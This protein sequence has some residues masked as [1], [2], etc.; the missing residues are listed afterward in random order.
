MK[1]FVDFCLETSVFAS[2]TN[3]YFCNDFK[4]Q[5]SKVNIGI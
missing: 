4:I 3:K 1:F 2:L 5:L